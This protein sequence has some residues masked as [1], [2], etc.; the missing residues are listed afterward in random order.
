MLSCGTMGLRD[1]GTAGLRDNETAE[2]HRRSQPFPGIL[3]RARLCEAAWRESGADT[4]L[5]EFGSDGL[6]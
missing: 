2:K 4:T 6:Y 5:G 1:G 3:C